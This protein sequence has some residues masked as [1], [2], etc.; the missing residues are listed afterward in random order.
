MS[1]PPGPPQEPDAPPT[2]PMTP[3]PPAQPPSY[4]SP[5]EPPLPPPSYGAPAGGYSV[6]PQYPPPPQF[7]GGVGGGAGDPLVLPPG[8]MFGAWFAKVQEIARRSWRSVLIITGV[9]IAG[10]YALLNLIETVTRVS[11]YFGPGAVTKASDF[12][13]AMGSLL[14]GLFITVVFAIGA[15]FVA[16]AGWAAGVWA[17]VQEAATGRPANVAEAFRYGMR[18]AASLWLWTILVGLLT[19]VGICLCILPGVYVA[20]ATSLFGMVAIFERGQNPI[21]RSFR[22]THANF[23]ATLGRIAVLFGLYFVY[24]LVLGVIFGVIQAGVAFG[25]HGSFTFNV[26]SGILS[27]VETMLTAPAYAF[28][29]I[30]LLPTYAELR[31]REAPLS[32]AQLQYELG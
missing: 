11:S 28:I 26:V 20:F 6:P 18:R 14:F 8:V 32:T 22:L 16:A 27:A 31:A 21:A 24:A 19:F 10:P 7:P 15:S 1:I 17:L 9:G 23:G 2:A 12:A 29:L 30:G 4:Q 3:I 5:F 13:N 25:S